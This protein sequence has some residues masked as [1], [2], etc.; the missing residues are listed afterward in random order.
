MW[1]DILSTHGNDDHVRD[2]LDAFRVRNVLAAQRAD[3]RRPC[4]HGK[5]CRT[6]TIQH[7]RK[8]AH[9]LD[10]TEVALSQK[11]TVARAQEEA[12]PGSMDIPVHG[13]PHRGQWVGALTEN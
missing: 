7:Y 5:G 13:G 6:A 11:G 3:G 10:P 2:L 1:T 12:V 4:M 9:Q 8:Y